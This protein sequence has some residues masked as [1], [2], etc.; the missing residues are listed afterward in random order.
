M[1]VQVCILVKWPPTW[2]HY[3]S[4]PIL[5]LWKSNGRM[6]EFADTSV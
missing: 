2:H 5:N 4:T 6:N 3:P 1:K